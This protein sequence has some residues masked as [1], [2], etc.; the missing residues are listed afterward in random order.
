MDQVKCAALGC[1]RWYIV[2]TKPLCENQVKLRWQQAGYEV[3]LPQARKRVKAAQGSF[4]RVSALFP[5]YIFVCIDL[6]NSFNFRNIKY[7]RGVRKVLGVGS[8]PMPVSLEV[9]Q[10]IKTRM[11]DAGVLEERFTLHKGEQVKV[12]FGYLKDLVGVLEKPVSEYGR[13]KVLLEV[14]HKTVRAEF[15]CSEVEKI[16]V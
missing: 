12:R 3:F 6:H 15:D 10:L 8:I 4:E 9:V 14:F 2:Q 7:T 16:A 11:D 1:K 13:V 5:G